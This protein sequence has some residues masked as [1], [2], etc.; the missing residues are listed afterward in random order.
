MSNEEELL[1]AILDG[2]TVTIDP[3]SRMEAYLKA[4]ANNSGVTG[5]PDPQS[6]SDELMY[7]IAEQGRGGGGLESCSVV[8]TNFAAPTTSYRVT[9]H[10]VDANGIYKTVTPTTQSFTIANVAKNTVVVA[11]GQY[12]Y[13][14]YLIVAGGTIVAT[15]PNELNICAI[16][17]NASVCIING[18]DGG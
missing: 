6:R 7:Q 4:I 13:Q 5:L 10:Y 8:F 14:K 9:F 1:Q 15:A 17:P 18:A 12:D 16:V 3:Q 2:E 11:K